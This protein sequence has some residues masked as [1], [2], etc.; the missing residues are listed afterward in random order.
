MIKNNILYEENIIVSIVRRE[1]PFGVA[2]FFKDDLAPGLRVFEI[3]LGYMEIPDVEEILREAGVN[4]KAIFYGVEDI[5]ASNCVWQ[6]FS[7]IK[8]LTPS[9]V[10]FYQLPSNK[11]H[12]VVTKVE[13]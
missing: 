4:E 13:M 6:F 12:G 7:V 10:Q 8:K 2:G 11:L 1:D 9:L 5:Y 3:Q